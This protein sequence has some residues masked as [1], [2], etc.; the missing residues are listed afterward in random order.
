MCGE[1]GERC[2]DGNLTDDQ[3]REMFLRADSDQEAQAVL[4]AYISREKKLIRQQWYESGAQPRGLCR[5]SERLAN[6]HR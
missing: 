3:I 2:N 5:P 6:K 4:D 1:C